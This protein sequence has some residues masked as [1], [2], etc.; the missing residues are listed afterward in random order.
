MFGKYTSYILNSPLSGK[1]ELEQVPMVAPS[2][3]GL[4]I[5]F[6]FQL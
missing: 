2:N 1:S 4:I 3:L 5:F 6:F